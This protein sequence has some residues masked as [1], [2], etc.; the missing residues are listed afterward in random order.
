MFAPLPRPVISV[1][2]TTVIRLLLGFFALQGAVIAALVVMDALKKKQRIKRTGFPRPGVFET[3]VADSALTIYTYGEDLYQEMLTAIGGAKHRIFL[4]TFIWKADE[5][6]R[7]F[8]QAL[9]DAAERGVAVFVIYDGFANL[10]VPPS[11]Y[12]L[13]PKAHVYR[14]PFLRPSMLVTPIRSTGVDHRKLLI[15][16][17]ETGFVGGYNIGSLYARQWRD[18]HV[19]LTG[20]SVWGLRQAFVSVWNNNLAGRTPIP[21]T[22]PDTWEPRI[23]ALNNIPAN[24]VFPIRG[25]YLDAID[26]AKDHIYITTAYFIPDQ[27]VLNALLQASKRGVDVRIILPEV[28]NHV[29]ADWLSRGYYTTLLQEGVTV[30]LYRNAMI[31]A[32]TATIDGHWSTVGTANL[33]RLSLAGN[34]ETHLEIH[35]EIFAANME[36]VFAVDSGNCRRLSLPKWRERNHM[37]RISETILVPLRP[38]L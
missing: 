20:P 36:K 15:V 25:V 4:E 18:T 23:A 8:K 27:R 28:S 5:T 3:G 21:H 26:R 32:K 7:R 29:L 17:E 10:T 24:L 33:D 30:L 16:D 12:R 34:Y 19:K 31:H 38:I 11:F 13:H 2:K 9:A 6:G 37:A 22:T 1:A 35:D 14:F